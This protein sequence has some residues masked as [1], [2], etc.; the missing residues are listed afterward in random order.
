MSRSRGTDRL[1]AALAVAGGTLLAIAAS[2]CALG[3]PS[4]VGG[5]R[6][7]STTATPAEPGGATAVTPVA[8][9]PGAV[10]ST[11]GVS[12]SLQ[13]VTASR[14]RTAGRS[15]GRRRTPPASPRP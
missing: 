4:Q 1:R 15:D 7:A 12:M 8:P 3:S 6:G 5:V 9:T 13:G 10:A 11:A 2:G 14:P